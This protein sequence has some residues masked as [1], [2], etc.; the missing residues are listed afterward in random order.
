MQAHGRLDALVCN[1]AEFE[2]IPA[3]ELVWADDLRLGLK[4]AMLTLK[5]LQVEAVSLDAFSAELSPRT[6]GQS[7][8]LACLIIEAGDRVNQ[9]FRRSRSRVQ[10][11][12]VE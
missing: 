2:Q 1:A 12:T 4:Q 5:P 9:L 8:Q 6:L 11:D 7:G 10:V 3:A